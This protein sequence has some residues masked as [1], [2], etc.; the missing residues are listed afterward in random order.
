MERQKL[1]VVLLRAAL[2]ASIGAI[3]VP[4]CTVSAPSSE[5]PVSS[6]AE[7][8]LVFKRRFPND[9]TPRVWMDG[10]TFASPLAIDDGGARRILLADGGGAI[11]AV[12]PESG[13]QTWRITLPAPDGERAFV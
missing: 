2:G 9:A 7:A 4:A 5:I 8:P 3:V 10:C 6:M 11:T 13:T 12:D 1:V